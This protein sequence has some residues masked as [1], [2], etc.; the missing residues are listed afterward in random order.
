MSESGR[1]APGTVVWSDLT[2]A[3]AGALRDF[4]AAVVGWETRGEVATGPRRM[5]PGALCVIRDPAG[6]VLG[7]YQSD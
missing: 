3:D 4:Y 1:P 6:A 2:V 7:L 5:G